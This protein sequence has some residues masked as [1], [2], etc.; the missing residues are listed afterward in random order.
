MSNSG[1]KY[2]VMLAEKCFYCIPNTDSVNEQDRI[3]ETERE[4][5]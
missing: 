2:N 3:W 1:K 5:Q 4:Q